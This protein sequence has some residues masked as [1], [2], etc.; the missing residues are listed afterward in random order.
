[1]TAIFIWAIIFIIIATS[2]T[3][4]EKWLKSRIGKDYHSWESDPE[5]AHQIFK[6]IAFPIAYGSFALI[7]V[8][9]AIFSSLLITNE[10]QV[11]F[12]EMLG[13]TSLIDSAGLHF[14][15]PFIS[16]KYI[17]DGTTH[18]IA[19]GYDENT[20]ESKTDD[21][22]MITSDFNFVNIDF[23]LEYR[24]SDPIEYRYGSQNP[25]EVLRNI[26]QSAIRNTVGQYDVDSVLTTGKSEIE[27]KV[28]E[29]IIAELDNHSLGLTVMNVTIQDSEPPTNEVANAFK[30]VEN[31]KQGAESVINEAREY[32]NTNLP[33]AEADAEAIKQKANASK[34]ERVNAAKEEVANFEALFAEYS[35]N[36]ET[37]KARLYYEALEEILPKMEIIISDDS[38]IVYVSGDPSKLTTTK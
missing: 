29:D 4:I 19:I 20:D 5:K 11:G 1:M 12:T 14:K 26:A 30:E 9:V 31:A 10:Q 8:I 24:I 18:G 16:H 7:F 15:V 21:S 17:Y 27:M 22:L 32:A 36:P 3:V 25:E 2:I 23:Y 6:K 13:Q 33:A 37:V 38:N 28:Y 34:T 35:K